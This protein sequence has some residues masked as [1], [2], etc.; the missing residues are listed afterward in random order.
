MS[1]FARKLALRPFRWYQE[2]AIPMF[3]QAV[4]EGHK[5]IVGQAP[6]GYGKTVI[7]AH[8]AVSSMQKG[9]KVLFAC[10][11]I[12]LVDQTLES[13]DDQG[14]HDIGILQANHKRT[15]PMCQLQI[16]CFDTL[17]SRDLPDFD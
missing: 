16:A 11:R 7:A 2:P 9:N 13:F 14:I 3:R 1:L 12:S 5:K 15:N 17:Y 10:P 6:C 8:L 4:K